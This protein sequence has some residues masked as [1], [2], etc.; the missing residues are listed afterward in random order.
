MYHMYSEREVID[1]I[2]GILL[3]TLLV[4]KVIEIGS[5]MNRK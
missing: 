5:A 4:W 1:M 3:T 2:L